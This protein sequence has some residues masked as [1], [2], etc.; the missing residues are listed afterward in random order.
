MDSSVGSNRW[1]KTTRFVVALA[2]DTLKRIR[3]NIDHCI[4]GL[5]NA[6]NRMITLIAMLNWAREELEPI[7]GPAQVPPW[8]P[9]PP[10]AEPGAPV[11]PSARQ[12]WEPIGI[13]RPD[14]PWRA[15]PPAPEPRPVVDPCQGGELHAV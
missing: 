15:P 3:D 6:T 11:D 9:T 7:L 10:V 4:C 1:N 14:E 13:L 2:P 5:T 8:R 12:E